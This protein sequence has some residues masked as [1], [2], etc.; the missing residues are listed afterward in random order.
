MWFGRLFC[1]VCRLFLFVDLDDNLKLSF[2]SISN[3]ESHCGWEKPSEK[4]TESE[5]SISIFH[6]RI[7]RIFS[8]RFLTTLMNLATKISVDNDWQPNTTTTITTTTPHILIKLI[9]FRLRDFDIFFSFEKGFWSDFF[10]F[11]LL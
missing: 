9:E 4:K 11:H 7:F 2:E 5:F 1:F 3:P 6:F 10:F 8:Y